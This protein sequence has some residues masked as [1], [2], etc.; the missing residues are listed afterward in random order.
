MNT[1]D[2]RL[3]FAVAFA[4]MDL[5]QFRP[6]DWLNLRGDLTSFLGLTPGS[7]TPL[8]SL[9]GIEAVIAD[10]HP[11]EWAEKDFE[12][13]QK[14]TYGLLVSKAEDIE[15]AQIREPSTEKGPRTENDSRPFSGGNL[16]FVV[17]PRS[18]GRP[19]FPTF[20]GSASNMFFLIL[21]LLLGQQPSDRIRR[22]PECQ[23]LFLRIRKQEYCSRMCV[24]RVNKRT[25]REA[26]EKKAQQRPKRK[27]AKSKA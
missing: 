18:P 12:K 20:Y 13:L 22:C 3:A 9:G 6:G 26:Q 24:N 11:Q 14:T 19:A 23:R 1:A 21:A 27:S 16:L 8:A 2:E 15:M 25:W 4:Q 7:V 10:P 5:S 17:A